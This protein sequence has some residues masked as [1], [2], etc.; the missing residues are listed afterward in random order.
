MDH[1]PELFAW[2]D[3]N[4]R[5]V[6]KV[7]NRPKGNWRTK[8]DDGSNLLCNHIFHDK[9]LIK[10]ENIQIQLLVLDKILSQSVAS[11]CGI[12]PSKKRLMLFTF[13]WTWDVFLKAIYGLFHL[14]IVCS[15]AS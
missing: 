7:Q 12:K 5:Y 8:P 9:S 2:C 3:P 4:N 11:Y 13:D 14:K 6:G 1:N 15:D 10:T